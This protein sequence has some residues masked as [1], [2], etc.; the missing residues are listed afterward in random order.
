M[1]SLGIKS[2]SKSRLRAK[3]HFPAVSY[4]GLLK[5]LVSV[6]NQCKWNLKKGLFVVFLL[7][8]NIH[9]N[10]VCSAIYVINSVIDSWHSKLLKAQSC[11]QWLLAISWPTGGGWTF[12]SWTRF[13]SRLPWRSLESAS[14]NHWLLWA[15]CII[16]VLVKHVNYWDLLPVLG[17]DS[18]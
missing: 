10:T 14:C 3:E 4:L 9:T 12:F 2:V 8:Y 11:C 15:S 17:Y 16:T 1:P 13:K 5:C 6:L 18:S 7:I